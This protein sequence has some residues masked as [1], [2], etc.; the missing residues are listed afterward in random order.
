[1][2]GL[3]RSSVEDSD[4][5]S[6]EAEEADDTCSTAAVAW[7]IGE[8]WNWD[9]KIKTKIDIDY[10]MKRLASAIKIELKIR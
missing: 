2:N 3:L 6:V 9:T 1:M 4:D 8:P 10:K 7:P 5:D